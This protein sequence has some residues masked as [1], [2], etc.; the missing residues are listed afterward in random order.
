MFIHRD[1]DRAIS[2]ICFCIARMSDIESTFQFWRNGRGASRGEG[3][4]SCGER[5]ESV[6]SH[7]P[8][9]EEEAG[10]TEQVRGF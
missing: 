5:G 4:E 10:E 8:V 9:G 3:N 2:Q 7:S 1:G 6:S